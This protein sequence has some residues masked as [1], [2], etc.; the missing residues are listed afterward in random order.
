MAPDDKKKIVTFDNV[1]YSYTNE[2]FLENINFSVYEKDFVGI[3]G[4]NGGGKT[5]LLKLILGI[6]KPKRGTIRIFGKRP[7]VGRKHIGYLSQFND[8]DFDFPITV[9]E[10]VLHS[11][12]GPSIFKRYTKT[13][14]RAVTRTLARLGIEHLKDRKLNELSGGQKQRVFVARALANNP[15]LLVLDEPMTNLDMSIQEEFY[16]LLSQLNERLAIVIVD[17]DLDMMAR[18]VKEVICVNKCKSHAIKY[19]P[20]ETISLKEVCDV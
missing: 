9:Y 8:I 12:I 20:S 19:H 16:T 10:V 11:R 13:D 3:I 6:L 5:T 18:Y 1:A 17:H 14:H 7:R 4:P 15:R 2:E